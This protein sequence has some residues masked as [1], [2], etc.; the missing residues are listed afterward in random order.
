[1]GFNKASMDFDRASIAIRWA[2]IGVSIE[3]RWAPM[4]IDRCLDRCLD[5]LRGASAL[6]D[7]LERQDGEDSED[8]DELFSAEVCQ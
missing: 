4:G 8:D 7:V 2:S 1:M 5:R 3:P 6:S